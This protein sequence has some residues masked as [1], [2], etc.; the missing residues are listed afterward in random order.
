MSSELPGRAGDEGEERLVAL[1]KALGWTL[2]GDTN[3]TLEYDYPYHDERDNQYGID[4]YMTYD[5]PYRDKERGIFIESKTPTF[6][7]YYPSDLK[8]HAK[9]MLQKVEAGPESND[10]NEYLQF[11]ESRIVN[12]GVLGIWFRD[13]EEYV[14]ER[15]QEYVEDVPVSPKRKK[16]YQMILLENKRLNRLASIHSQYQNIKNEFDEGD[17]IDFF[18]PARNDSSS[19]RQDLLTIEYFLSDF[20]FAKIETTEKIGRRT[21]PKNMSV[22]FYSGDIELRALNFMY[23]AVL[24]YTMDDADELRIYLDQ[25]VEEERRRLQLESI[26]EEF[27]NNGLPAKLPTE[28]SD[29]DLRTLTEENYANYTDRLIEEGI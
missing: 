11:E 18:Y 7:N 24:K 9:A 1:L 28:P 21:E 29:I 16:P 25:D 19:E 22:V 20:I 4:A 13:Q 2:R 15:F 3:I 10:F 14:P 8:S 5:G 6:D 12:A 23:R 27:L 17:S 26:T